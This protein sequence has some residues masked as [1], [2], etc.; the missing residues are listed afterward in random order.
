MLGFAQPGG[1]ADI[2]AA[3]PAVVLLLG[4]DEVAPNKFV[5]AY[6][7]YVGHHGDNGARSADLILPAASYAEKHGTYVNLEGRVQRAEKAV[8]PPGEAREDW[9]IFRALSDLLGKPL[10]FDSFH[11]LHAAMIAD[12]PQ[13]ARDGLI[14]LP[15]APPA[16]DAG[17]SGEMRYPIADFYLTNAICRASPTM[18]AC[19]EE[20]VHGRPLQEA[21][22]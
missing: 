6:K 19:S 3:L 5:G 14:D 7:V 11:Q 18:H 20:L 22:E 8:F 17:A 21:A 10:P 15:W 1:I 4:A 9:A 13:L 12:Y 16:L 2:E